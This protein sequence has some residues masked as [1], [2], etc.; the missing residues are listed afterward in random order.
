MMYRSIYL[1]YEYCNKCDHQHYV[2]IGVVLK[3]YIVL[4]LSRSHAVLMIDFCYFGY[5]M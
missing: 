2:K 4:A 3:A 1:F 5:E